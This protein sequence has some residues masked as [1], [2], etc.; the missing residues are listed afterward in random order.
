MVLS[1]SGSLSVSKKT[2]FGSD[3]D[4][5]SGNSS[6]V[7]MLPALRERLDRR[8]RGAPKLTIMGLVFCTENRTVGQGNGAVGVLSRGSPGIR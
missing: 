6:H 2:N 5:D 4:G 3:P 1:R 7:A 8:G